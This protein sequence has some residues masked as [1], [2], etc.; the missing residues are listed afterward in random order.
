MVINKSL[1][2]DF[3]GN[4]IRVSNIMNYES[5]IHFH[6]FSA[7][8][9]HSGEEY[10]NLNNKNYKISSGEYIVGNRILL[11]LYSLIVLSLLQVFV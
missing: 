3:N 6:S 4:E 1:I 8:Y 10:Y 7:K 9:V 5:E 11:D 2:S